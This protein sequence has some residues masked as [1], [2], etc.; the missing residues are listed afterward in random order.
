MKVWP[1]LLRVLVSFALVL[2][3]IGGAVAATR[4]DIDRMPM[5]EHASPK[6]EG[7]VMPCHEHPNTQTAGH[8]QQVSSD[9]LPSEKTPTPD[10]CKAGACTCACA[11]VTAVTL[12]SLQ[13]AAP[14][15]NRTP[16]VQWVPLSHVAPALPH[17]IR[18][19]IG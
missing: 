3:G 17:L 15:P 2:N 4:M 5:L 11:H 9:P 19:P 16:A 13:R 7:T 6:V 18:P 12:P 10:C 8:P 14:I 1:A